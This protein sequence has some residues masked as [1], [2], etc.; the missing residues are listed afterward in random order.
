MLNEEK[1]LIVDEELGLNTQPKEEDIFTPVLDEE[2]FRL[3]KQLKEND[4]VGVD[5]V[6]LDPKS[7]EFITII[8]DNVNFCV[9]E[10]KDVDEAMHKI[11]SQKNSELFFRKSESIKIL[12]EYMSKMAVVNQKT[13]DLLILLLGASGK[14]SDEYETILNTI[15]ELSELNNGEAEVLKYLLKVKNMVYEIKDND[16][17]LRQ[18]MEDN[19]KTKEIVLH[20]DEAFKKEIKENQKSRKTL[21]SKC[22]K[23]QKRI[24]LNNIY[25]G[26]CLLIII[27]LTI[28]VGVKFYVF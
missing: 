20:A 15:D 9:N 3:V 25:I 12:S 26:I 18:V 6:P 16:S 14:I 27:A 28:F 5:N 11:S 2:D 24:T 23:L 22:N 19:A 21:E 1:D 17:R 7:N 13:L 4:I 10:L 8:K